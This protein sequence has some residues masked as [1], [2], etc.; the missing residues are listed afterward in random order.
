MRGAGSAGSAGSARSAGGEGAAVASS[1]GIA[2]LRPPG[3][4]ATRRVG[5]GFCLLDNVAIAAHAALQKGLK[6]VAIVDWDVHHG[7]G[8][9]DI[10]WR[11]PRVLFVSLH[12]WPFYPG[13]GLTTEVG[14]GEGQGYTV[15][16]PLSEGATDAVYCAA[17]DEIVL[18][19]LDEYA[20]ELILVSAGYD[21]HMRDPLA[22]MQLTAAGYGAMAAKL[23][24]AAAKS[25]EGRLG[26]FLEGGYSL[27]ALEESI[28]ATLN[29]AT[30]STPRAMPAAG[31]E[32]ARGEVAGPR[33]DVE[34]HG[35][36]TPRHRFE[37]DRA[38]RHAQRYWTTL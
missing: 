8:T 1:V 27:G 2:L 22:A 10:F 6:R 4:H 9:Q 35:P 14:E 28:A 19:V 7:N 23:R 16:V 18:P 26:L 30:G 29:A 33:E 3:H 20:P 11:D 15:N 21:A 34:A 38:R 13:T 17:F 37:L 5:M 25:A 24:K 31:E 12:Q 36:V 32:A